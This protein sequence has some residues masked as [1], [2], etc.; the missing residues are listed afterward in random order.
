MGHRIEAIV[1][2]GELDKELLSKFELPCVIHEG[3]SIVGLDAGHSDHWAEKLSIPNENSGNIILNCP[4]THYFAK[5]LGLKEYAII[6]TDYFGGFGEQYA[7]VYSAGKVAM[8]EMEGGINQALR[9]I[10]VFK[11]GGLDEF[12]T[13]CLGRY[14]SF[15]EHFTKYF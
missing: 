1:A 8:E 7:T 15:H 11:K 3:F 6:F 5:E 12:D 14:R 13:I 4:V 2:K 10:G 9:T